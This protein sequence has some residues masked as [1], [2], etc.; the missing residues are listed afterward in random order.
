MEEID[1]RKIKI[2]KP[3]VKIYDKYE[4]LPEEMYELVFY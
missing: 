3:G 1:F 4:E 2:E